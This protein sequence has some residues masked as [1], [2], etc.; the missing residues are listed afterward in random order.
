LPKFK[1]ARL[2]PKRFT[3]IP[4]SGDTYDLSSYTPDMIAPYELALNTSGETLVANFG[5]HIVEYRPH[6]SGCTCD[7]PV[8]INHQMFYNSGGTWVRRDMGIR[9]A[10]NATDWFTIGATTN[11]AVAGTIYGGLVGG[12]FNT[13]SG[14]SAAVMLGGALNWMS[15][16]TTH[17]SSAI[18]GGG[19][20]GMMNPRHCGMLGGTD[21]V[22]SDIQRGAIVGGYQNLLTGDGSVILASSGLTGTSDFTVY[23]QNVNIQQLLDMTPVASLPDPVDGRVVYSANTGLMLCVGSTWK[24]ITAV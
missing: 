23:A 5:G 4:I 18:V 1:P 2:V 20:N 14:T 7:L 9:V 11:K 22:I 10:D 3:G 15:G 24:L 19:W 16:S 12:L 21:N 17:G 6:V 8:G 13:L